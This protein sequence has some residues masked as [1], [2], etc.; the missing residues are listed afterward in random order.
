MGTLYE[1]SSDRQWP[2]VFCVSCDVRRPDPHKPAAPSMRRL[3]RWLRGAPEGGCGNSGPVWQ[4]V[5]SRGESGSQP[6]R[7][8]QFAC[9]AFHFGALLASET[10]IDPVE[11]ADIA[12]YLEQGWDILF[13]RDEETW[14][15]SLGLR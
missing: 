14:A 13:V 3:L 8:E 11:C 10:A 9:C 15:Y 6:V 2:S 1:L 7:C 12:L 4:M 5:Q